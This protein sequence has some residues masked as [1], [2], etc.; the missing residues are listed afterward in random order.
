[1]GLCVAALN[2]GTPKQNLSQARGHWKRL[3][4]WFAG[5]FPSDLFFLNVQGREVKAGTSFGK[6][7]Q[8][9]ILKGKIAS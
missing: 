9:K 2:L 3:H 5:Y 4:F 8:E 6:V 1:M 7:A